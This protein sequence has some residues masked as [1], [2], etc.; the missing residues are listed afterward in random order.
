MVF[1]VKRY[2]WMYYRQRISWSRWHWLCLRKSSWIQMHIRRLGIHGRPVGLV[3][4][5][6]QSSGHRIPVKDSAC[7]N[8]FGSYECSCLVGYIGDPESDVKCTTAGCPIDHGCIPEP[9][10]LGYYGSKSHGCYK[11][12]E[13]ANCKVRILVRPR[14]SHA[15][16]V[17]L[18][19]F[20]I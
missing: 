6:L 15:V 11:L 14:K 16:C 5:K 3:R 18:R 1:T 17:S 20:Q 19:K 13:H 12:P 4:S 10:D 2:W 9:C 8:T 7:K